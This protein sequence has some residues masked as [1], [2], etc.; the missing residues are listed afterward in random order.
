MAWFVQV[1]NSTGLGLGLGHAF[2]LCSLTHA[3]VSNETR[4]GSQGF[5]C[6][7]YFCDTTFE[8]ISPQLVRPGGHEGVDAAKRPDAQHVAGGAAPELEQSRVGRT[9][10]LPRR[11]LLRLCAR[12]HARTLALVLARSHAMR[13]D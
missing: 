10:A 13:A 8:L 6:V 1:C 11:V 4:Q 3:D 5:Q 2:G 7:V 12:T 9:H